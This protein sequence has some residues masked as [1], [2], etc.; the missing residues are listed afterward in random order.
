[1]VRMRV[2]YADLLGTTIFAKIR[3]RATWPLSLDPNDSVVAGLLGI[4]T[5]AK[6]SADMGMCISAVSMNVTRTITNRRSVLATQVPKSYGTN[7]N[8]L[9]EHS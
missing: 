8:G 1:M 5:N 3:P 9:Q 2:C 4:S 7:L 6:Y